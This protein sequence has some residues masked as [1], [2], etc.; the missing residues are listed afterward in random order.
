MFNH[1]IMYEMI[2]NLYDYT[3]FVYDLCYNLIEQ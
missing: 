1:F 3:N 2:K